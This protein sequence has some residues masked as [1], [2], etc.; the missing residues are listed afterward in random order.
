MTQFA[1]VSQPISEAVC[2]I[3]KGLLYYRINKNVNAAC[4]IEIFGTLLHIGF[5]PLRLADLVCPKVLANM[6]IPVC[7]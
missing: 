2:I 3:W 4:R 1:H 6:C 5:L 7:L